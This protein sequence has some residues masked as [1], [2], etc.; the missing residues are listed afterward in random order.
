[1]TAEA[2]GAAAGAQ[3]AAVEKTAAGTARAPSAAA[4][5]TAP[6]LKAISC[7]ACGAPAGSLAPG[8]VQ[9]CPYCAVPLTLVAPGVTGSTSLEVQVPYE[10]A[11]GAVER[12][13]A[14][15]GTP[16][17]L[18]ERAA[19]RGIELTYVPFFDILLI[20]AAEERPPVRC[21]M[22]VARLT[23]IALEEDGRAVGADRIDTDRVRT[24]P[25]APYDAVALASRGI[26]LDPQR[27]PE[28]IRLPSILSEP[29]TI[30]RRVKVV[31][32]PVWLAR[33]SYGHSLYQ[34]TVDG[35]SGEILRGVAPSG[36]KRRL[37]AGV[38]FTLLFSLLLAV[39]VASPR[40]VL[41]LVTHALDVGAFVAGG[42]LLVLAAAW[43]RLRFK[44]ELVVEG[45]S[46]RHQPINRPKET[47]LEAMARTLFDFAKRPKKAGWSG[48]SWIRL[49]GSRQRGG[50][51]LPAGGVTVHR[52]GA[53]IGSAIAVL[54]LRQLVGGR[55]GRF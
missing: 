6:R 50:F 3:G 27:R 39:V 17:G 41:E 40:L 23:A 16:E 55:R 26:V 51:G 52:S 42:L 2:A 14:S 49:G 48:E 38:G 37:R 28:T 34:V 29:V 53:Q 32:Y 7:P 21:R 54:V 44:R 30:E 8:D 25:A 11:R 33:F 5:G 20:E 1:V 35:V 22:G 12:F 19:R 36:M 45:T 24:A 15:P 4:A 31:Y 47:A 43:D 46:V 13:L 9:S 18:K 10:R